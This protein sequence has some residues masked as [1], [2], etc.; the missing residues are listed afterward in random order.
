MSVGT[1]GNSIYDPHDPE[2]LTY[3]MQTFCLISQWGLQEINS[4]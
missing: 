2:T 3:Q 1:P 4:S